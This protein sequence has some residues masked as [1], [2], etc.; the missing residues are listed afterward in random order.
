MPNDVGAAWL[1][2][3]PQK[4]LSDY[5]WVKKQPRRADAIKSY[6]AY[7]G[8]RGPEEWEERYSEIL[9][10]IAF[11]TSA[12]FELRIGPL[13]AWLRQGE[14]R[15]GFGSNLNLEQRISTKPALRAAQTF[16]IQV[17]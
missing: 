7:F 15:G 10:D 9:T 2:K 17:A 1:L 11:R 3:F 16:Q 4:E 12:K 6:L 14:K 8:V 5:G 13:S